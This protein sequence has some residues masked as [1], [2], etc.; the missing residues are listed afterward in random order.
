[1]LLA[2]RD[3][4]LA[5][6]TANAIADA[7]LE[8]NASFRRQRT[9]GIVGS[10]DNQLRLAQADLASVESKIRDFRSANP[11]I[12]LDQQTQQTV[13]G[14]SRLD[15]GIQTM[16][17]DLVYATRLRN[18]YLNADAGHRLRI[19]GTIADF[20]SAQAIPAG[21]TLSEEFN[22]LIAQQREMTDKFGVEH[23]LVLE[24]SRALRKASEVIS[25][26]LDEFLGSAQAAISKK[27]QNVQ[28]LSK[29]LRQL[30]AQEMQLGELERN[31][32]IFADIY[33]AVLGGF[34]RAKVADA[35]ETA[36]FYLMDNA[37]APLPPPADPGRFLIVCF[38]IAVLVSVGPVLAYDF[39]VKSVRSQ[40]QLARITGNPVL[41]TIPFFFQADEKRRIRNP[42]SHSLINAPCD[43][44]YTREIFDS[45]LV[46][47]KLRM[48][49]SADHSIVVSGF[50]GGGGKSTVSANLAIATA[51]RG[52]RVLLV[53]GDLRR[54]TM[55][56][57]FHLSDSGGLSALL[58]GG[59]SLTDDDCMRLIVTTNIPGL[60]VL[61]SGLEPPNPGALLSSSRMEEFKHFTGKYAEF[62]IMDTPPLGV[63]SDA[64]AV[65]NLFSHYLFVVRSGKTKVAELVTRINEFDGLSEKILGYVLNRASRDSVGTYRRYSKYYSGSFP[66]GKRKRYAVSF[67]KHKSFVRSSAILLIAASLICLGIAGMKIIPHS[68]PASGQSKPAST[69]DPVPNQSG[70]RT[71]LPDIGAL[72]PTTV[73]DRNRSNRPTR[74]NQ[75][76][77]H[78]PY[79]KRENAM[80]PIEEAAGAPIDDSKTAS[81]E[82]KDGAANGIAQ[83]DST[84]SSTATLHEIRD[85]FIQGDSAGLDSIF[86]KPALDDGEYYL[87]LTRYLCDTGKW[88]KALPLLEKALTV[89]SRALSGDQLTKEYFLCKAKCL[90]AAFGAEPTPVRG[91]AA[92]EAWFNVKY[93]FRR[94]PQ[95]SR[96]LYANNELH[97]INNEV[98]GK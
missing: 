42:P 48:F 10:L 97:R 18:E 34:N 64:A 90:S 8:K 37:V 81:P 29:R 2:G 55:K 71:I 13:S 53:D 94:S 21:K 62:T 65:Q 17:A 59:R 95:D 76:G 36:D 19:T 16:S 98:N 92:M 87:W 77:I 30:P 49:E 70:Y 40:R 80:A 14:L 84:A 74:R 27:Q 33:S 3:Y 7:F 73:F 11:Q 28:Q 93:Q 44:I 88:R 45:L 61:P 83:V 25:A 9:N 67:I 23:P 15:N 52:H 41:E 31:R 32:K 66:S 63:V 51:M 56:K 38:L 50:E 4:S 20:L 26:T 46:K 6:A 79:L 78:A 58:S 86:T 68:S 75:S 60:S 12:G 39:F 24:N 22:R 43:P 82:K 1:V 5:A 54:G 85:K 96:Y 35:V 47:I 69:I 57:M 91:A 89:P 72:P